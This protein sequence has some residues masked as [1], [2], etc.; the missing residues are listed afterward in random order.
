MDHRFAFLKSSHTGRLALFLDINTRQ[1]HRSQFKQIALPN[2]PCSHRLEYSPIA[3]MHLPGPS[4]RRLRRERTV[5]LLS[6]I[7]RPSLRRIRERSRP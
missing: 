2:A 1:S 3:L 6:L 4:S 5:H 7:R